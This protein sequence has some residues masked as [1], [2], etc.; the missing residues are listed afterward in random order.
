MPAGTAPSGAV[1]VLHTAA[2]SHLAAGLFVGSPDIQVVHGSINFYSDKDGELLY[3]R[4]RREVGGRR[5]L[6]VIDVTAYDHLHERSTAVE[7]GKISF[8]RTCIGRER[9]DG[10]TLLQVT[11]NL[12]A[13]QTALPTLQGARTIGLYRMLGFEYKQL[14]SVTMDSD[15]PLSDRA[16]LAAQ[17]EREFLGA[18]Q[19]SMSECCYRSDRRFEPRL[20]ATPV[21]TGA[22]MTY[23]SDDVLLITGGTRGIGAAVAENA[24]AQGCRRLVL[25]GRED[26]A[27][28][29]QDKKRRLQKFTDQGVQVIYHNTP[30]ADVDGLRSMI[31]DI[32]RR[33]GRITGVFHCAGT[34]GKNPAFVEKTT[35]EIRTVCGPKMAGLVALHE[36]LGQEPLGFFVLFSSVSSASP[37]LAAGMSD[38]GMANAYMDHYATARAAQGQTYF[39]SIQWPAWG[40]VGMAAGQSVTPAYR[41]T[42]LVPITTAEGLSFL[43]RLIRA[44]LTVSLPFVGEGKPAGF[45]RM[46]QTRHH[47][48]P[49]AEHLEAHHVGAR[50]SLSGA[51]A[52]AHANV[53]APPPAA[54]SAPVPVV[55]R[56][57][58]DAAFF[59]GKKPRVGSTG[60][61]DIAI[62]GMAGRYPGS[63][64]VGAFWDNLREGRD[65]I[66]EIPKERWSWED[67]YAENRAQPGSVYSKWGGFIEDHDRFDP[68]FFNIAPRDAE[69]MDPQERLFLEHSWMALEDAGYT[70]EALQSPRRRGLPVRVG[71]Y[72]GVMSQEYPLFAAEA[73]LQGQRIGLPSGISGIAARVSYFFN[74]NGPSMAV[75]TMCSSSL[76]SVYLACQALKE[77]K[78]DAALAGGVNVSLHPNKYLMLSQA[79]FISSKGRCESFGVGGDGYIPGEGVGV[80]LLKRLADAVSDGDHIY[81]VIKGA[82]INHGGKASGFTVPSP[83]AQSLVVS[84]AIEESGV[85]ARTIS[86]IEAHGTG[87]QLGDPIE[88]SGLVE[89]F[90]RGLGEKKYCRIGSAKSNIGHCEAAAG[91]AGVT[92]VLLQL[93]HGQLAPSLHS[94]V[95]NP[96]IDFGATPFVVNQELCRWERPRVDGK[97][98]PRRAGI[99][100]FGAGGANAHLIV[101][102]Y[103][104]SVA[105]RP[106]VAGGPVAIVLSARD[107][108]RLVE[109]ARGLLKAVRGQGWTDAELADIAYTLQVGREEME[110][111]LAFTASTVAELAE[112]LRQFVEGGGA[113]LFRGQ[114][115][116]GGDVG[117]APA[118]GEL[119][120]LLKRWVQGQRYDWSHL[121]GAERPRRVSLPTYPFARERY[122]L[123]VA[124]EKRGV[125]VAAAIHPLL[126]RNTSGLKGLRF[127]STF[128]GQE[129]LLAEQ[130]ASGAR[131]VPGAAYLEMAR[132]AVAHAAG[133]EDGAPLRLEHVEW[134]E[135]LVVGGGETTVHVGLA[136]GE[137]GRV[138]FDI[139]TDAQG[140]EGEAAVHC[141]G[142][143]VVLAAEP[144]RRIELAAVRASCHGARE[145]EVGALRSLQEGDGVA[146]ARV[147]LA[148]HAATSG[149]IVLHPGLLEAVFDAA[150][151]LRASVAAAAVEE[152]TIHGRCTAEMWA[153]VRRADGR[154]DVDLCDADGNVVV[155]V[156]RLSFEERKAEETGLVRP[157]VGSVEPFQAVKRQAAAAATGQLREKSTT[158]FKKLI[159]A[160]LK[161]PFQKIDASVPLD[162]YGME[163]VLIAQLNQNLEQA[164]GEISSTVFFE[165]RTIDAL[166]EYFI[167]RHRDALAQVVGT[168]AQAPAPVQVAPEKK[169]RRL[170]T[171][172][173]RAVGRAAGAPEPIA[174]IGMSG[175]YPQARDLRAY[176]ENLRAGRDSVTEIPED[177]WSLEGF[178]HPELTEAVALRKS[179]GKWGGFV[180]GF[181]EFDPLFFSISPTD[182]LNMDPQ[183]RLFIMACWEV[184]EDAG[185]SREQ[186][187]SRFG[188]R[189]GV[190][191][192]MSRTGFDLLGPDLWARGEVVHPRTSFASAANRVSYLLDLQ[193]PS[194]PVDTM[195]S[196]SLTAIHLACEHIHRGECELA[197]AGG[198]NLLLHPSSYIELSAIQIL[199][200]DG[201]CKSFGDGG[202]GFVPGEGVGV[203]LLKRLS[204]AIADGDHI[205]AVVRATEINHGGRTNGYTVPSPSAQGQLIRQALDKA[206]VN[207]RAVSYIEAHGTGTRLGD[208]IEITGLQQAFERDTRDVGFCAIGAVKSNIGHLEAAA[209]IAAV[210]KV[211][212][213]M[214]HRQL[215]PS[216][217]ARAL[218]PKIDF[219]STPFVVQQDLAEWTRPVLELDGNRRELPRIAGVSSFGAGGANAHVI[220]EEHVPA[221]LGAPPAITEARPAIIVLSA[222]DRDRL[223]A[224]AQALAAAVRER[225]LTDAD[226]ADVAYTLQVG[227]TA[228]GQ[229]LAFTATSMREVEE[230]L[231]WF[232]AGQKDIEGLYLGEVKRDRDVLS[233]FATDEDMALTTSTWLTKGKYGIVLELWVTGL[234]VDWSALHGQPRPRRIS[235]P[236]YPFARD[237]Y[238]FPRPTA[239]R[240]VAASQ[241]Q[242]IHPLLHRDTS[243]PSRQEFTSMLTGHEPFLADHQVGGQSVLPGTAYLEMARAAVAMSAGS[244]SKG[245]AAVKLRDVVWSRPVVMSGEPV[246]VNI[247]LSADDGGKIGYEISSQGGERSE[248]AIHGQ[249]SALFA[250]VEEVP[251][252]DLAALRAACGRGAL[253][254]ERVYRAFADMGIHYGP[255][256]RGVTEVHVGSGELLAKLSLP[257]NVWEAGRY[258]IH[259]GMLDSALQASLGFALLDAGSEPSRKPLMP[260]SLDEA[261]IFG[262][263][264]A[265]MWAHV[266]LAES[267]RATDKVQKVDVALCDERGRVAIRL[268]GL[269]SRVMRRELSRRAD[270][271]KIMLAPVWEAFAPRRSQFPSRSARVRI[272]GGT[273]AQVRAIQQ[274]FPHAQ[275]LDLGAADTI[276]NVTRQLQAHG[277]IEQLVWIAP[278]SPLESIVDE[279]IVAEQERGVL[280][281]FRTVKALLALGYETKELDWTVVTTRAQ[282]VYKDDAVNPTHATIHGFIGSMAKEFPAWNVRLLD[283][284]GEGSVDDLF[285]LP[286]DPQGNA[287][288][289]RDKQWYR[290]TLVPLTGL[291]AGRG[292][293]RRGGVYVVIGGA[294]GIGE[295]WS[296]H[297]IREFQAH[298]VWIGRRQKDATIQAKLDR[299][300]QVGPA[301]LYIAADATDRDA[302]QAAYEQIKQRHPHVHGIVHSALLLLDKGLLTMDEERFRRGLAPKVEATVRMAQVF[303]AEPLDFVLYF[304]SMSAFVKAS[305]QSNYSAGCTFKDAYALRM[306]R[307]WP[308]AVKVMDWGYWGTV[309]TVASKEYQDRMAQKGVGSIEPPEAMEALDALL[310]GPLEQVAFLKAIDV[311]QSHPTL[312]TEMVAAYA[313]T[314]ASAIEGMKKRIVLP[315]PPQLSGSPTEWPV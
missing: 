23:A 107:G 212:L 137:H 267:N 146:L 218:N 82:A 200:T 168:T 263:C 178:F 21:T 186:L 254:S 196:S 133:V 300:A 277:P 75:D 65:C 190:F 48:V 294:G 289:Y 64:D 9:R 307:E 94:A 18:G 114:V 237:V 90:G 140:D 189:V 228:M 128:T 270:A 260:F 25:M 17:I 29:S 124:G 10:L 233:V 72:A 32:H 219:A 261:E 77:G 60:A 55:N 125:A 24:V 235:L 308:C 122:W 171:R 22:P 253:S 69:L 242:V 249:G 156:K 303:A 143:A 227:R 185:Y 276:A 158:Y 130:A 33:A 71:V 262:P 274:R 106:R 177:R 152:L 16:A 265:S 296:E 47:T 244:M 193:G 280:P 149:D 209:G 28:A 44:K 199:S 191:A 3:H 271:R 118:R 51:S 151:G 74:F 164:F 144:V 63:Y 301:P 99:S 215:V 31:E 56:P 214:Q 58:L 39:R 129:P 286:P 236:T 127:S 188:G 269:S 258:V 275:L 211:V 299:L 57:S 160:T 226:L 52:P 112:K 53:P 2:T 132:K 179:Y 117:P 202:N 134:G 93:K 306:A 12:Q 162:E 224:Y 169:P 161:L 204:Q 284:A 264:A 241:E 4:V 305:G 315:P 287:L 108:E 11:H 247:S 49:Q 138:E 54:A 252:L 139:Y 13:C 105:E 220:L 59:E 216:L 175:R 291:S 313:E 27:S 266:T 37:V 104:S 297:L 222:R 302:L 311:E 34:V 78:I 176:W 61:L 257:A 183:E 232:A 15:C 225:P 115:K 245:R 248:A 243:G 234:E 256:H 103:A 208:P 172:A 14:R 206:G 119:P 221:P 230:K 101:E 148:G 174:I 45:E 310:A 293:Y 41:K 184:F 251:V 92:K 88:V 35:E 131:V 205:Y 292:L 84:Q 217:H 239:Q 38:Y 145:V 66:T 181:A 111:R 159:G 91:V 298:V 163:S 87:T 182:A 113:G 136:E 6:G 192:G 155:A 76:T 86:Y 283:V 120:E 238:W 42:G 273:A 141:Q 68:V 96:N 314:T 126:H 201:R 180:D 150:A 285:T 147:A 170:R 98:H 110:E 79:Q 135:P 197:V 70:R 102:E 116:R 231:T 73:S 153:V 20:V 5:V 81:G 40:E 195:C 309:G 282:R 8:L 83:R 207:A 100:S 26:L 295:I 268:R 223:I 210:T 50:T 290:Q 7:E 62:V 19:W 240:Q 278:E 229:R 203:V 312:G 36:A 166:V 304:S 194:M 97:E 272:A 109:H 173:K 154:V 89:A 95:L 80:L 255:S 43:D 187:Q 165:C 246:K 85:D 67:Y 46:L 250:P 281:L 121:Y 167:E 123:P 288:A 198:V 157:A 279:S 30:L 1:V 259:P 213:Q 142:S